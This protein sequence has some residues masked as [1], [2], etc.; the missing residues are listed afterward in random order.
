MDSSGACQEKNH[1]KFGLFELGCCGGLGR[2]GAVEMSNP[3]VPSVFLE[4][5]VSVHLIFQKYLR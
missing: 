3:L 5:V 2:R 1:L 4:K